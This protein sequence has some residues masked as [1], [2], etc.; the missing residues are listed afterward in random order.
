MPEPIH[1]PPRDTFLPL[2]VV[3][4][5]L[6]TLAAIVGDILLELRAPGSAV[7][8]ATSRL[9]TLVVPVIGI[10][11]AIVTNARSNEAIHRAVNGANAAA[12]DASSRSGLQIGQMI[13]RR[14]VTNAESD[15]IVEATGDKIAAD[16]EK[17]AAGAAKAEP[18]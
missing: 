9:L 18:R 12:L 2:V 6:L 17:S 10:L 5:V 7:S 16:R 11:G 1:S 15:R 4:L 13:E 3:G 8:A 14:A